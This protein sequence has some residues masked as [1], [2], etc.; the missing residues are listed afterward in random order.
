MRERESSHLAALPLYQLIAEIL[1]FSR[2]AAPIELYSRVGSSFGLLHRIECAPENFIDVET[3]S[4]IEKQQLLQKALGS[5]IQLPA[6]DQLPGGLQL[7]LLVMDAW[8][9]AEPVTRAHILAILLC[10]L[11]TDRLQLT[12]SWYLI[13]NTGTLNLSSFQDL[14]TIS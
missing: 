14:Y 2:S 1:N 11:V 10:R 6:D 12:P 5:N 8:S 7:L 13:I 4:Q 3:L 9:R